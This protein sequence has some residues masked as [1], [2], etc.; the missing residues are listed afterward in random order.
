MKWEQHMFNCWSSTTYFGFYRTL[1]Q[2]SQKKMKFKSKLVWSVM[3]KKK[4]LK[5]YCIAHILKTAYLLNDFFSE[6]NFT[7]IR[8]I[9]KIKKSFP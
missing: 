6:K 3:F 8:S 1:P 2:E 9:T 7:E 5:F 4:L